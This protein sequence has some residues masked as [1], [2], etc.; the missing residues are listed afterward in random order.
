MGPVERGKLVRVRAGGVAAPGAIVPCRR[1]S[2]TLRRTGR[3]R[4]TGRTVKFELTEET[5]QA[6]EDY[7]RASGKK[8]GEFP[9]ASRRQGSHYM[10]TRTSG[11]INRPKSSA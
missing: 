6:I 10:T 8:L 1:T 4:K 11:P 3:Q 2:G 5:R 9:F 7:L